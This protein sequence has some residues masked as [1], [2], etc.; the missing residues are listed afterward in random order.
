MEPHRWLPLEANPD[1]T[2]Q[3]LKQL[4]IHP[5]WQFVD[6]YGMEPELLSMVPRPVCAVLLLFPITE[7]YET[8]RTEEE[9]RIKAKGQDVKSSVYFM[10]Q[11]IN[12][13]CGTIGLIHA[14]AN[15]RDKMNFETNSSLKKF[16]E[17]SLSM[18]PEERAKYLETYEAIRVTHESSAHEGQTES[19]SSSLSSPPSSSQ[20]QVSHSRTKASPLCHSAS[21]SWAKRNHVGPAK[22]TSPSIRLRRW[23]PLIRLPSVGLHSVAPSIDEKVDLH[24]IA[25]VNVGGHL[26]ELDGRKPFPINHGETSDESF[27]ED[28]IEVCKK[29]M[30]RDPE[31]LRFNAIALSAA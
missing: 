21:L 12:N 29:F 17:D 19:S 27:L 7:K 9:E 8:F 5:D 1:V 14:I 20:P 11:T 15:N 23:R 25:L 26:Y 13:A 31:E 30:E 28:A 2:N 24:F 22:A 3:F 6:V 10:K 16:L 18:T 4:G